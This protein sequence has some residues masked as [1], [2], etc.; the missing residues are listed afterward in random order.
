M[1]PVEIKDIVVGLMTVIGIAISWGQYGNLERFARR[2]FAKS[3]TP[4]GWYSAPFFPG[5]RSTSHRPKLKA[6]V[7]HKQ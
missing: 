2:E 4:Q 5:S 6:S 1:K 3:L 7:N